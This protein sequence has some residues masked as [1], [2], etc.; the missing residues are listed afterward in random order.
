M[1]EIDDPSRRALL[2]RAARG[3]SL[4][5]LAAA[6][7]RQVRAA[8]APLLSPQDPA[9]VAVHYVEDAAQAKDATAGANCAN[10]S[11]YDGASG[12]SKGPCSLF[13]GKLVTAA[14][15]CGSWSSL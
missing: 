14:G 2:Q 5:P 15:W 6:A 11:L 7:L 10:C 1:S 4:L 9:A 12:A 3:L 8:E 13:P